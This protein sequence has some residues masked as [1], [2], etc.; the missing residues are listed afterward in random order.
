MTKRW[1]RIILPALEKV[2]KGLKI[3]EEKWDEVVKV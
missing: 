2:E 3:N 1:P